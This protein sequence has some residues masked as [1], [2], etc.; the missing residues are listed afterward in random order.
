[1][2]K[3]VESRLMNEVITNERVLSSLVV[4]TPFSVD[5]YTTSPKV[6]KTHALPFGGRATTTTIFN[7]CFCVTSYSVLVLLLS[8]IL[9]SCISLPLI[10]ENYELMNT[11]KVLVNEQQNLL[12]EEQASVSYG[13]LFRN[14]NKFD[15]ADAKEVIKLRSD[16]ASQVASNKT[17]DTMLYIE[18]SG[19]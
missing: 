8:S 12:T 3:I 14:A 16:I 6:S 1:M 15:F 19:Y 17:N 9:L 10:Y 7:M 2:S 11:S 5:F 18:F 4:N 13:R